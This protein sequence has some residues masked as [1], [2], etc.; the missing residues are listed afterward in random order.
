M[1]LA[2]TERDESAAN[3]AWSELGLRTD[4]RVVVLNSSGAFGAA[5]LWPDEY[6]AELAHL[7]VSELDYDVLILCGPQERNRAQEIA[8]RSGGSRVFTLADQQPTI[9]LSKA[10]VRR[11]RLLVTTDSGPRHFAAAFAVPVVSLFGPTHM[12]WSDTHYDK[13]VRLQIPVE[14]GPCQNRV[15]PLGH[16]KCMRDL[17]VEQVYRAVGKTLTTTSG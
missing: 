12:Q 14:C 13:E 6:F 16:H 2:V 4:G 10:C 8:T 7:I 15:C 3:R 9:G 11:S 1:E 5:K 17:S